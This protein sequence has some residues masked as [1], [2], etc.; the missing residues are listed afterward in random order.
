MLQTTQQ[1]AETYGV[2]PYTITH[3]WIPKGLK[4]ISGA[5][6]SFLFKNEWVEEFLE[7]QAEI[8]ALQR[9]KNKQHTALKKITKTIKKN[10]FK[11]FV[12]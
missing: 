1:I 9:L 2:T 5:K 7:S 8:C 3:N 10:N 11:C 12:S 6:K 4:H